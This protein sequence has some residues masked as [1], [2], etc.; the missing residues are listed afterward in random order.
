MKPKRINAIE[1]S[2]QG[3]SD[4][5]SGIVSGLIL[6]GLLSG[7]VIYLLP[8]S[9]FNQFNVLVHS[10]IGLLSLL[11]IFW[12]SWKHW[13]I[14]RGGT[15]NHYQLLGYGLFVF[16]LICLITG[17]IL[18]WQSIYSNQ[19]TDFQSNLHLI[20]GI[21]IGV[22]IAAHLATLIFRKMKQGDTLHRI[23][24]TQRIFYKWTS[25]T[26]VIYFLV[27]ALWTQSY[28]P[29]NKFMA[30][31]SSYNWRFGKDKPFAPSLALLDVP[32][33]KKL[34]AV[35]AANPKYLSG[36]KSCGSS[37]CHENIYKEWLPSAHR[38][39]SMD[40]LF[41]KVQTIMVKETTA[42]HTRYCAGCHDP[43]SLLSGAKDSGNMTL[44]AEGFD[45]GSSCVI[46]HSISQTDVQGNGNYTVSIPD[47][48]AYELNS[49]PLSKFV[50]DFLIR[51]YPRHHVTSYSKPL[52]KTEE[53]CA[54]CHK[55]YLDKQV[56]TDIGKVQ[57]Q[58]QYD[59]W[60]NS[61]W[62]HKNDP[63]KNISCRECHMPL[64][65]TA[66]PANGDSSDYYRSPDDNKHRSHRTLASNSYIPQLLKLDGADEQIK[67]TEKWLQ[68]KIEIPEIADK[69]VNGPVVKMQLSAT[70]NIRPGQP[71]DISLSLM[72]NK[73]GHD[74]PTGPL[75]MIESW[76]ELTVTDDQGKIIFHQGAI[77]E[78]N[79]I[80]GGATFRADGFDRQGQ[81]INRH[82]LWDLVGA[83][84]KR[85]L[86]PGRKDLIKYQLQC[87]SM[88]R[89]RIIA[90]QKGVNMG[91]RKE[92]MSIPSDKLVKV[93]GKLVVNAKLWYRKVN[94]EFLNTVYG[95]GHKKVVP[96]L[97]MT[98][99]QTEIIISGI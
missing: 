53:F 13:A 31:S 43:I 11:P 68:G 23:R 39:S 5:L 62:Y 45:E 46:C 73:T 18:T 9:S 8:F 63:K 22:L 99:Q 96:A 15:L 19:I 80:K 97:L 69:W 56:N 60:K 34:S 33:Q 54:A 59:S 94:P 83:N 35:K 38:Y 17:L 52:Y 27:T 67:L 84:Y 40:E 92:N 30:F 42:E 51:A 90:N 36:S 61:R 95:V 50:S 74:F 55:Q 1:K 47:R 64:Q 72:N 70:K 58:N 75:D 14:R 10:I 86:F 2:I 7:L 79:R 81:L 66:D 28:Q 20:T 41:Q 25:F 16:I 91:V 65:A 32:S 93:K 44:G 57:G 76:I 87:P 26:V 4:S 21:I 77:D 71:I 37:N 24:Q 29:P 98:E 88:A 48:Y 3:W 78:N 82:N 85:T 12:Y 6:Y 49:D 89:G